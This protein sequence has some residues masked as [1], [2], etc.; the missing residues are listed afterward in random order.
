MIDVPPFPPLTWD[1]YSWSGEVRLP[2]WAGF[3]S[4]RGAYASVS[5]PVPSDGTAGLT[6]EGD[7]EALPTP[8]QAAAFRYHDA[9]TAV[10]V[11]VTDEVLS[12]DLSDGRSVSVPLGWYPR[13]TCATPKE[14]DGWVLIGGE[15]GVHWPEVDEDVSVASLLTGRPSS[16]RPESF[17]RWLAKRANKV[18]GASDFA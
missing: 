10:R 18:V 6:V 7:A 11:R 14:R 12:L 2:S 17:R 1:R 15:S 4:R 3:Q 16:E 8:Q 5:E 13:L 9:S